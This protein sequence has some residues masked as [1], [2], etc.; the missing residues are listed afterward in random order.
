MVGFWK[1]N[2]SVHHH[3]EE[4]GHSKYHTLHSNFTC[5]RNSL[6]ML[7]RRRRLCDCD[8]S[9]A[10]ARAER[11][12]NKHPRRTQKHAIALCTLVRS[13]LVRSFFML[14]M[15]C[16]TKARTH[17]RMHA[18]ANIELCCCV[19]LGRWVGASSSDAHAHKCASSLQ[20]Q[21][22]AAACGIS[23]ECVCVLLPAAGLLLPG[24]LAGL[25]HPFSFRL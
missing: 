6:Y 2:T 20:K 13:L 24:L 16:A 8:E 7:Q 21:A 4:G 17:E 22:A 19:G 14:L 18:R 25:P 15:R 23:F 9:N 5:G 10:Q 3:A 11:A 12:P 1:S